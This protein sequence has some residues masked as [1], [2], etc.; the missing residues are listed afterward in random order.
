MA[1]VGHWESLTEA[2]KLVQS[3]L[4]KGVVQEVIEE[5]SLFLGEALLGEES[6]LFIGDL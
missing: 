4:L 3:K 2:Q 5:G 1:I 6:D